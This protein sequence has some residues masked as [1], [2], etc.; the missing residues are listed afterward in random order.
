MIFKA[1]SEETWYTLNQ[2]D[3]NFSIDFPSEPISNQMK[4]NLD[5]YEVT[6]SLWQTL[7]DNE[8]TPILIY[9]IITYQFSD[10]YINDN[11]KNKQTEEFL[12]SILKGFK[13]G[14]NLEEIESSEIE[15]DGFLGIQNLWK[16]K[17]S[18]NHIYSQ[19]YYFNKR[20]IQ[21]TILTSSEIDTN[22][23]DM[24]KFFN[25]LKL[26]DKSDT[27]VEVQK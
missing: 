23:L 8:D 22:S 4:R 5:G 21:V 14:I 9:Q 11:Y 13:E 12:K 26:L 24:K 25:S 17:D 20:I 3:L 7:D 27:T 1:F 16:F 2:E 6:Y 19:S 18:K 10:K 15:K